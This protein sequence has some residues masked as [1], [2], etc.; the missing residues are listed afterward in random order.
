MSHPTD[1]VIY[2]A[3]LHKSYG[4]LQVLRGISGQIFRGEVVA[5]IGSSGCGKSTLL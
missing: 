1:A 3:N 5:I 2:F 4:D